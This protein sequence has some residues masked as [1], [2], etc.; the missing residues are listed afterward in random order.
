M[1]GIGRLAAAN[2]FGINLCATCDG[3]FILFEN[4]AARTFAQ[5]EAVAVE[6]ER[7]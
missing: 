2:H 5:N 4:E 6:V 1:V 3:M 7:T